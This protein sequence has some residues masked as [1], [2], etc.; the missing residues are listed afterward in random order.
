[1]RAQEFITE[2]RAKTKKSKKKKKL[3]AP[4]KSQCSVGKANLS[5]VRRSQCVARGWLA[6]SPSNQHTDGSGTQGKKG[7]GKK[8]AGKKVASEKYGGRNRNYGG[9]HS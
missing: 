9:S 7:T 3:P 4:S 5:N 1:M 8:L 6:H 2:A